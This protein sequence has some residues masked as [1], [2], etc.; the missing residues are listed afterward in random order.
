MRASIAVGGHAPSSWLSH[1][2][3]TLLDPLGHL[4]PNPADQNW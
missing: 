3:Q 2:K 1:F 4:I